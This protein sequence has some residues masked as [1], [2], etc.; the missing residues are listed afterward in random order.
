[1]SIY[2]YM[3]MCVHMC[4]HMEAS[5]KPWVSPSI[6]YLEQEYVTQTGAHLS[7]QLQGISS[8]CLPSTRTTGVYHHVWYLL[9]IRIGSTLTV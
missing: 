2:A 4:M 3:F 9:V 6:T 7:S 5:G 1:M 8:L